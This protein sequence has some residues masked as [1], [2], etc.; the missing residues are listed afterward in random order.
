[1]TGLLQDLRYAL[2]QLRKSPG[3]TVAVVVTLALGIGANTAIFSVIHAVLLRSLPY[4]NSGSLMILQEY[5]TKGGP[6]G[7]VSWMNYLDWRRR[8][9][10]FLD[11]AAY[12]THDFNFTGAKKPE[13]IHGA[14]VTSSFFSLC[15]ARTAIGRAFRSDEDQPDADRTAVLSYAFWRTHF[16]ADTGVLGSSINLDGKPYTVIGVLSPDFSYFVRPVDLYLPAALSAGPGSNWLSR[17]NHPGLRVLARLR[18]GFSISEAHADM[19]VLTAA[20]EKEYPDVNDGQRASVTPLYEARYGDVRPALLTLLAGVGCV[21]LIACANVANLALARAA[22]RQREFSVRAAIGA[23]RRRILRQLL[24]ES[25]LLA[26]VGGACGLLLASWSIH[27]LLG[28][29]PADIPRLSETVV[30]RSVFLFNLGIALLTG[31]LFGVAPALVTSR[32]DLATSLGESAQA[33]LG[34]LRGQ[35]LRTFLLVSEVAAAVVLV[36]ASG[37]LERSLWNALAVDP[38]FR[39]DHLLAVDVN[40][41]EYRYKTDAQQ[42]AFLDQLLAQAR[43]LPAVEAASAAMCPPLVGTCWNSIFVF[44]DRPVPPVAQLPVSAFNIADPDYFRSMGIPLIAGRWFTSADTA[45][46]APVLLINETAARRWWPNQSPIGKH[47]KQGFPQDKEPF[48]EVIGVVGDLKE[49]GPDQAQWAEMFQPEAQ[50][51]M[52]S[53]TLVLR[54]ATE[55]MAISAEVEHLI[56]GLDPDQPVYHVKAMTQYLTESLSRRKFATLLLGL[57]GAL[58]LLLAAVG[59]YGVISY[60]VEQRTREIGVRMA[61]G[62]QRS[63]VLTMVIFRGAKLTTIG[64][65]LG[66]LVALAVTRAMAGLLFGVSS[67]DPWTFGVATVLLSAVALAACYLPARRA[68]KVDPMVALRYE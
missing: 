25:V 19:D 48:R 38:G 53:F 2:R 7:S 34:S 23:G 32:V 1:M 44:D 37:L 26:L 11:M 59:T 65:L 54:T 47:I 55:P 12:N 16:A 15:G 39:A 49:E 36:V 66:A 64:V 24:T 13:V 18:P 3:F 31:I 8:N 22:A 50:N 28:L 20:L 6:L 35:R 33:S 46:S 68:A 52:T 61:L 4:P 57:F 9:H 43:Q 63:E 67:V 17:G 10:S 60:M 51:T 27:P 56:H 45:T 30:D 5:S 42:K 14:R 40:L 29:A 62:A 58:A 41:P 21:L